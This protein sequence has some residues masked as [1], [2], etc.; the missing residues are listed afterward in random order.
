MALSNIE[1][2]DEIVGKAFALL[3]ESFPMPRELMYGQVIESDDLA[4][5]DDAKSA[6]FFMA[7]IQWL[8]DTGYLSAKELQQ[9]G[10]SGAVLTAKGL[11]ALKALPDSLQGPIG[12]RLIEAAK[13][14][15][16]EVM[17]SLTG[18]ALGFGLQLMM[19]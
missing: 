16:R 7:S 2:F 18:Q 14:D 1:Q 19:R 11:E 9:I 3:Y 13:T 15:G 10:F 8:I 6:A 4:E 12:A 5:A 17:R